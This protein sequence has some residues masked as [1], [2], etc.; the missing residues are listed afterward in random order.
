MI[1]ILNIGRV[2]LR[3][4]LCEQ[5]SLAF[6]SVTQRLAKHP[7]KLLQQ[8]VARDSLR[9][10]GHSPRSMIT[11]FRSSLFAYGLSMSSMRMG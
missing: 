9:A 11:R 1:G 10:G 6:A 2:R 7:A 4:Q 8:Y 3:R 5:G